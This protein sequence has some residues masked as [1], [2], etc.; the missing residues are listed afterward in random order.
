MKMKK[1]VLIFSLLLSFSSFAQIPDDYYGGAQG[2]TGRELMET[3]YNS[4]KGHTEISY[5]DLWSAF[6][7]T[8]LRSD[9]KVWD[10]Y[11]TCSFTFGVN[12]DSGSGGTSE[13]QYYN[14]EHSFPRSWFGGAVAPM[15]TDLFHIYPADKKV[16]SIRSDF[17]YGTVSSATYTSSNGSK[18]GPSSATGY[19]GTVFEPCDEYKGDFARSY[20]YM[21]TRYYN[22]TSGWSCEMFDGTQFPTFK[23]W[24]L[25]ILLKW[26]QDDPVSLKEIERNNMIFSKFQHNRNPYIDQPNFTNK[27]WANNITSLEFTSS[28]V[29]E[30]NVASQYSYSISTNQATGGDA[31]FLY[32][33]KPDWL[34]LNSLGSGNALLSGNPSISDLGQHYVVLLANNGSSHAIQQFVLNVKEGGSIVS[35]TESLRVQIYPNPT[36]KSVNIVT[37]TKHSG[38]IVVY[39]LLGSRVNQLNF[40]PDSELVRLDVNNMTPGAYLLTVFCPEFQRS[41]ILVVD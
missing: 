8:D 36:N 26:H 10:M 1:N 9:G 27:V 24:A 5:S 6:Y 17:P 30:V 32:L 18:L 34:I 39:N 12:Q 16:N 29:M 20:F 21:A 37:G 35:L 23:S 11:S 13:C 38:K 2:K 14:R 22:L 25:A 19:S 28:P 31:T 3:L 33:Q 41:T 7:E 4:I 40:L 15:N